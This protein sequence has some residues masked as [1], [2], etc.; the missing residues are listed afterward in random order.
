M[1]KYTLLLGIILSFTMVNKV[2]AE[3]MI[4]KGR[5]GEKPQAETDK[6]VY[7]VKTYP[8]PGSLDNVPFFNSN[9]P[10]LINSEGILLSTFPPE[11]KANPAA[12]L[13]RTFRGRFDIFTHHIT[14]KVSLKT[15]Y[16]GIIIKNPSDKPVDLKVL[17]SSTYLTREAPFKKYTD[18][19]NNNRAD[20]FAGPGDRVSQDIVRDKNMTLFSNDSQITIAPGQT[21]VFMNLPLF[22]GNER[23]SQFKLES[24]GPVYLADLAHLDGGCLLSSGEPPKYSDWIDTLEKGALSGKRDNIPTLA[25]KP[26][27]KGQPFIYGRVSGVSTGSS[28]KATLV[29]NSGKFNV[30]G[31]GAGVAYVLNTMNNNTLGTNQVQTAVMEQRYPDTAYY[32]NGNYGVNYDLTVPLYNDSKEIKEISFSFDTPVR[33]PEGAVQNQLE[34]FK[35]PP[36]RVFFRGELKLDYQSYFGFAKEK[37]FHIVQRSGQKGGNLVS[38]ILE[39]GE[40]RSLRI[41]YVYPADATAPHV[42]TI[43]SAPFHFDY[44]QKVNPNI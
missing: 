34:Y 14:P 18:F 12:H 21:I 35:E 13:N 31:I 30:S 4:P 32:S 3:E 16:Q 20:I 7:P 40:L 9:S 23:T 44:V 1:K 42:L 27:S 5:P 22:P 36:E 24:D 2:M 29:N 37:Y 43:T 17:A 33:L 8:L 11:G 38:L 10:E 28:W 19:A 15:Y 25:D 26:L 6:L 41:R 39:P